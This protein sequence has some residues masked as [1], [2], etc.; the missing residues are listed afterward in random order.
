M[1]SDKQTRAEYWRRYRLEK[2]PYIQHTC[3]ICGKSFVSGKG[4]AKR[5]P[6]CRYL[7][8]QYCGKKFKSPQGN[9][10]QKYC[11]RECKDAITRGIVPVGLINHR[12]IKPRTYHITDREKHGSAKDRDWRGAIF[13]R[14]NYTCQKCGVVGGQ[15]QAH[16]KRSWKT[17]PELRWDIDNG[18]TLCLSCHRKTDTYGGSNAKKS[19]PKD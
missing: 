1:G 7:E 8:C 17:N 12:G 4:G 6:D 19:Q 9:Y 18:E 15:L 2:L 10:K 16:H 5:C 11:S 3:I 14:D 13:L